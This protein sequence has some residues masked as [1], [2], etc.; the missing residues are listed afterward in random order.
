MD[1]NKDEDEMIDKIEAKD[2]LKLFEILRID[3]EQIVDAIEETKNAGLVPV[4]VGLQHPELTILGIPIEFEPNAG[5]EII[6]YS[7]DKSRMN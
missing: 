3:I 1:Y 5:N 4:S 2:V 6:V 7:E